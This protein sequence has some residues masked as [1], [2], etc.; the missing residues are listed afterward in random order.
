[1]VSG[2]MARGGMARGGTAMGRHGKWRRASRAEVPRIAAIAKPRERKPRHGPAAA[3]WLGL[4][5][6]LG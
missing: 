6:G 5:L 4:G 1:M 2:A 3:T